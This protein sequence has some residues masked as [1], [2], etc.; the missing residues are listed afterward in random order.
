MKTLIGNDV[1][2]LTLDAARDLYEIRI[3]DKVLRCTWEAVSHSADDVA[4]AFGDEAAS[5]YLM[6]ECIEDECFCNHGVFA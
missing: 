4:D 3:G 1:G 5:V 2:A 6:L